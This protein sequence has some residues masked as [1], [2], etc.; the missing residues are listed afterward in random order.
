MIYILC[1]ANLETGGPE[2]LHQLGYKLNLMGVEAKMFY[3]NRM[4]DVD[5]VADRY[6]KY[7]VPY[8]NSLDVQPHTKRG[9]YVRMLCYHQ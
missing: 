6:R 4:K 9:S 7:N 3:L 8:S 1:P 2:V 5:P